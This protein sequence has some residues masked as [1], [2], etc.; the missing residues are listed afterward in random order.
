MSPAMDRSLAFILALECI[1]TKQNARKGFV[2]VQNLL[3]NLFTPSKID[4]VRSGLSYGAA[5]RRSYQSY[6]QDDE[7]SS[8]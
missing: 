7:A 3:H 5:Q 6:H 8:A 2:I 4:M 1:I